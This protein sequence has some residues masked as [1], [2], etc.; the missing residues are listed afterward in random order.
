MKLCSSLLMILVEISAKKWEIW[1]SEPHF[2]EV[3]GDARPWLMA[4]WKA[5]GQ[6]SIHVNW[7]LFAIFYSSGVMRWNV[8]SSAVFTGVNLFS[9][10]FYLDRSSLSTI[11]G[12]RKLET[13][14]YPMVKTASL[15]IASFWQNTGVWWTDRRI[16]GSIY[17][18]SPC[19][20]SF[21]THCI[22]LS[23]LS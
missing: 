18:Y 22:K 6:L 10:K 12:A 11:L 19:K 15:C 20:A 3:W 9:L 16:W 14:D 23:Q 4:W 8:Y 5:H 7:T 2:W 13:L 17:I 21:V 1:V